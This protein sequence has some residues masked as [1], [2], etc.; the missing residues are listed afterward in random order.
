[1]LDDTRQQLEGG[2][3]IT[4]LEQAPQT[5]PLSDPLS[6]IRS[7]CL[8]A[9]VRSGCVPGVDQLYAGVGEVCSVPGCQ[10]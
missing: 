4:M 2:T 5:V 1:M 3:L 9:P 10:G 8:R 6:E 7:V